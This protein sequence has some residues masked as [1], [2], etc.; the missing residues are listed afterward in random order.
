M[1]PDTQIP[2]PQDTCCLTCL[3]VMST[4][5]E[6]LKAAEAA[7]SDDNSAHAE[8]LDLLAAA[9]RDLAEAVELLKTYT[10]PMHPDY[11][12]SQRTA[13]FLKRMEKP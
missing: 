4:L 7:C 12:Q 10:G 1:T 13:A 6:Q 5:R 9:R 8:T 11:A 3:H 2:L